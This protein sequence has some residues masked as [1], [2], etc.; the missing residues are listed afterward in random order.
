MQLPPYTKTVAGA[1][2]LLAAGVA[3]K[4]K[5]VTLA[6]AGAIVTVGLSL[7]GIGI[8]AGVEQLR[9]DFEFHAMPSDEPLTKAAL[10]R[11]A[12]EGE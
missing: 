12:A 2:V 4:L 11:D 7:M 9:K 3:L 10:L 1:L 8:R 5:L 6:D